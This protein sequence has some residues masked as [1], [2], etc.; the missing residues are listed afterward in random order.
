MRGKEKERTQKKKR[1]R[2]ELVNTRDKKGKPFNR[3]DLLKK[4]DTQENT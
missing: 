1:E 4:Y 2:K 3:E